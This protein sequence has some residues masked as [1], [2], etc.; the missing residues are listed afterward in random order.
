MKLGEKI[1]RYIR[2]LQIARK[3]DKEEFTTTSKICA[4]GMTLIGI[5][6]FI[7][8]IVFVISGI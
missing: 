8:F 7:I 4:I 3:P 2:V 5:I 1:N 6:G